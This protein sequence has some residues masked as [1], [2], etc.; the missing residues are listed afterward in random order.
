MAAHQLPH[1]IQDLS[2]ILGAAAL[3][4]L[5]F[6]KLKQPLVLGYIIAGLLV[7]PQVK[8]IPDVVDRGSIETWAEIGVI[9]LLFSLGLEFSFR[10]L[11]KVGGAASITAFTEIIV[12]VVAGYFT[13]RAMGWNRVDCLFLGGM[14]ASSSTT[15][16]IR[17]FDELGVKA[18]QFAR[19]V[20]GVLIVED[21]VVILILVLLPTIAISQKFEG[22]EL[23]FTV[24][25]LVFFLFIWFLAGIFLVPSLLKL[26][27]KLINNETL[28][29]IA[30]GMCFGMVVLA[31][32]VGF[33]AELGAFIMG[34]IF[35]ETT[36]AERIEHVMTPIRELFGAIFFVSIG[37]M[38]DLNAMWRYIGPI[39]IITVLTIVGKFF[40]TSL[41]ALLSGQPLKQSIRVGMSMAQIGEFAFIIATLGL[42]LGVT[43]DFLFPVAVGVAVITTF[44]TPYMI[45]YSDKVYELVE[46]IMPSGLLT[47]INN[48]SSYSQSVNGSN[49]WQ[50]LVKAYLQILVVNGVIVLAAVLLSTIY[51]L[52]FMLNY[53]EQDML[54][55]ILTVA[56]TTLVALP[57]VWALAIKKP[58]IAS[59]Y[60][61][62]RQSKRFGWAPLLILSIMRLAIVFLLF[63][64]LLDRVFSS[65]IALVSTLAALLVVL[66][67]FRGRIQ[68]LYS[69][70]EGRFLSNLT[71]RDRRI[72]L[73]GMTAPDQAHVPW[74]I[75]LAEFIVAPSSGFLGSSL[76]DLAWREQF[77]IN[78]AMIERPGGRD[79]HAPGRHV[80]LFPGD[81]LFVIGTEEQL[82]KFRPVMETKE[83]GNDENDGDIAIRKV[84]LASTSP[85]VG[86]TI[87][88]SGIREGT[89]GLVIGVERKNNRMLNPASDE[90]MQAGDILW[91]AG[92]RA[93]I[94]DFMKAHNKPA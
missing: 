22:K 10:K 56:I 37:M 27:K 67:L 3:T 18:K 55:R 69:S 20:F 79:I 24:S 80:Q 38:I 16:I 17:A 76:Q 78:V 49:L 28:L 53:F 85:L 15:I 40:S 64:F 32:N 23:F 90:V 63:G 35:A 72:A 6:R 26:A 89:D 93:K 57:F 7:G 68:H 65:W 36:K 84:T 77:G 59:R 21:I 62:V 82:E 94:K 5:I 19:T 92:D 41:G 74:D 48:Y 86:Q 54:A 71:E 11:V 61:I 52:P 29:V 66:F 58:A 46:K 45:R 34:S 4:T 47:V 14:L 12:I 81:R 1:I 31:V 83:A 44:T 91:L 33:S 13:G 2:L 51:L 30:V 39:T 73:A 42:S 75:Q 50:Q 25:K 9:F 70:I 87:R 88:A 43:S 60:E 8:I